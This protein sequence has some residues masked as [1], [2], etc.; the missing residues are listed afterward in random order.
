MRWTAEDLPDLTGGTALV[1]G[2]NNGLG[3]FTALELA[4]RG[5]DVILAG[6]N[7]DKGTAALARIRSEVPD[8]SLHW[9]PLDLADL[10]SVR[11]AADAVT[12]RIDG[13]D[14]LVN[15]AGVMMIPRQ[16]T[17]DGFETQ[18]AINHL[19][20]FALTGLLLPALLSRPAPRVVTVASNTHRQGRI[21]FDDLHGE[22]TYNR[23]AA[24]AQSKLANLVFA[25]E[26]ARRAA[27][28]PLVSVAAHP[29]FASTGLGDSWGSGG[30]ANA[31]FLKLVLR[32]GQPAAIG[33]LA[34]L[35]AATEPDVTG[36]E[37]FG[38]TGLGGMRG[39]PVKVRAADR[40]YDEE[41]GRRL[42]AAS[43]QL[44]GVTYAALD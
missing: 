37:Y 7:L 1:T 24:Y 2:A 12:A 4:R 22:R 10:A 25:Q 16:L 9:Q 34:T 43:E 8:A 11:A 18:L 31:L 20:H 39:H 14:L 13:L 17:V 29:G 44:T 28:T 38:P 6:R 15:N 41:T 23:S 26:L 33:A 40:A 36:G 42:W 32:F 3:L 30:L 21:D 27:A 35:R 19:G 5:A